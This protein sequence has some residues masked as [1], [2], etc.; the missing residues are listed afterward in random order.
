V[1]THENDLILGFEGND[2]LKGRKGDDEI[3]GGAGRD[4]LLGNRGD[5]KLHGGAD[6]DILYG[7][8]GNDMLSGGDGKDRLNGGAGDDVLEGGADRDVFIFTSWHAGH[9]RVTDYDIEDMVRLKGNLRDVSVQ[10]IAQ[11]DESTDLF[12]SLSKNT[13]IVFENVTDAEIDDILESGNIF[14]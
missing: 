6:R 12:L 14:V 4:K 8:K 1:G 2:W 11:Q 3:F 13:S 7:G 5:D 9:D 10:E